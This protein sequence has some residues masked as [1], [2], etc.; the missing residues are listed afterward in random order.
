MLQQVSFDSP[1]DPLVAL[2]IFLYALCVVRCCARTSCQA[3]SS[4][5]V[6]RPEH[7]MACKTLLPFSF[8]KLSDACCWPGIQRQ[9][10]EEL[11]S[12]RL[13]RNAR[14]S[15]AVRLSWGSSSLDK[16]SYATLASKISKIGHLV[17]CSNQR[18][19]TNPASRIS[20]SIALRNSAC[21]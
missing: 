21:S 1:T 17:T 13:S 8:V 14:I 7:M 5:I 16:Q 20:Q 3:S 11:G 6:Q 12:E 15:K 2:S 9:K 18:R 10:E 4:T 19:I